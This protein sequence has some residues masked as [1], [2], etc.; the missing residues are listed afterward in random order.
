MKI[1]VIHLRTVKLIVVDIFQSKNLV[2]F[3]STNKSLIK[4]KQGKL[5][6]Q[7]L[8][9]LLAQTAG[10]LHLKKQFQ[11]YSGSEDV[12]HLKESE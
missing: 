10:P 5:L 9:K 1:C 3:G 4:Q 8:A 2:R 6:S 12:E 11:Q 7:Y